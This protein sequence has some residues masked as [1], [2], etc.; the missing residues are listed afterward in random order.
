MSIADPDANYLFNKDRWR[1][2][3]G[4]NFE[5]LLHENIHQATVAQMFATRDGNATGDAQSFARIEKAFEELESQQ[6][7]LKKHYDE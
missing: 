5:T 7:R 1:S 3:N 2:S 6:K 4:V